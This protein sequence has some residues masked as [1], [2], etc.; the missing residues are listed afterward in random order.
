[1]IM[2]FVDKCGPGMEQDLIVPRVS[3][4]IALDSSGI[5]Y[6]I[7]D[8]AHPPAPGSIWM[9]N[10]FPK[11]KEKGKVHKVIQ[12]DYATGKEHQIWP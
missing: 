1:M 12:H 8:P 6:V 7:I 2:E 11:L 5:A 4:A 9:V 10:E 3:E